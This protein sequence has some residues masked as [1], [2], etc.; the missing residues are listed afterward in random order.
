MAG[1]QN[2]Q[3]EHTVQPE[4]QSGAHNDIKPGNIKSKQNLLRPD[5]LDL[6]QLRSVRPV[7]ARAIPK[8]LFTALLLSPIFLVAF[9]FVQGVKVPKNSPSMAANQSK[10]QASEPE[11]ATDEMTELRRQLAQ[12]NAQREQREKVSFAST[13]GQN[14]SSLSALMTPLTQ[15]KVGFP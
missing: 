7:S 6:K 13:R 12:A 3:L 14:L 15:K 9:V 4:T 10:A 5:E 11:D 8:A 1:A 2:L